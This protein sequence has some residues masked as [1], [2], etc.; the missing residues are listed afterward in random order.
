MFFIEITG[1]YTQYI[2]FECQTG[3][4]S[5]E[6]PAPKAPQV[7]WTKNTHYFRLDGSTNS[8]VCV[9][10]GHVTCSSVHWVVILILNYGSMGSICLLLLSNRTV[11]NELGASKV[12]KDPSICEDAKFQF[13]R[14]CRNSVVLRHI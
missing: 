12:S 5:P 3:T 11:D 8:Q 1:E 14:I 6:Y 2:T 9:E 7:K 4:S 13:G 10:C